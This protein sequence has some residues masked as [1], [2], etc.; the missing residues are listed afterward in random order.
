MGNDALYH[1]LQHA[2]RYFF[3]SAFQAAVVPQAGLLEAFRAKPDPLPR[4]LLEL[5][6][7]FFKHDGDK[8]LHGLEAA[9]VHLLR[10]SEHSAR[11]H[12]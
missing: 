6:D 3:K 5:A 4:V 9:P 8:E 7:K 1:K 2:P 12:S 11:P 10:D